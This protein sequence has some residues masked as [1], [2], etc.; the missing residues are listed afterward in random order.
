MRVWFC[1]G[2]Q[3]KN[4]VESNRNSWK[5]RVKNRRRRIRSRTVDGDRNMD[6]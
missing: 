1:G 4:C 2:K 3:A 5:K 6:S